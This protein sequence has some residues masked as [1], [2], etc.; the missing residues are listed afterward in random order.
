[1]CVS[2][3]QSIEDLNRTQSVSNRDLILPNFELGHWSFLGCRLELKNQ[4]FCRYPEK[5]T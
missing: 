4:H 3:I 2:L 5:L 1:M